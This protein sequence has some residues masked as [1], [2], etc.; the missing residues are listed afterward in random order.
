MIK[1][2]ASRVRE[3]KRD[4]IL[5][6]LYV[7]LEVLTDIAIP[8]VLADLIDYGVDQGNMQNILR[9]G[10]ILV[11]ITLAS[12]AFGILSGNKTAYASAG[13]GKNLR[14]DLFEKIQEFSFENIDKFSSASL[15]TR[16][17]TDVSNIQRAFQM[18]IRTA[19]RSPFMIVLATIMAFR[20]RPELA[21]IYII[22]SPFLALGLFL[23]VR[24]VHPVFERV[25]RTYDS[26]N[27]VVQENIG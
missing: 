14:G 3:Y 25:F 26:L 8:F 22:V 4:S 5:A 2:L 23:I 9:Y 21:I 11:V 19:V 15:I 18:I 24:K 7:F 17:T 27:Q 20:V 13:F 6:A 1:Q 16:L 10:L 12:L